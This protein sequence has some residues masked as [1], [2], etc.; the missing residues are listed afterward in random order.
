MREEFADRHS[1]RLSQLTKGHSFNTF[2]TTTTH[3][4]SGH[5]EN[6]PY[7]TM[8]ALPPKRIRRATGLG[9]SLDR[10]ASAAG[11]TWV[12]RVLSHDT[13]PSSDEDPPDR[14]AWGFIWCALTED[15]LT[16]LALPE[17]ARG[18]PAT[19]SQI[20]AVTKIHTV[21]TAF[22]LLAEAVL[23]DVHAVLA[24][25]GIEWRILKG[26]AT[27][28]LW[29]EAPDQRHT[30]DVD[31]LVHERDFWRAIEVLGAVWPRAIVFRSVSSQQAAN[32][33]TFVHETGIEIDLHRWVTGFLPAFR[34]PESAWWEHPQPLRLWWG[35]ASAMSADLMAFHVLLHL[36]SGTVRLTTV[37]D[38]LRAFARDDI[39]WNRVRGLADSRGLRTSLWWGVERANVW[40]QSQ[41]IGDLANDLH[42]GRPWTVAGQPFLGSPRARQ[43]LLHATS[44]RRTRRLVQSLRPSAE[45]L[46]WRASRQAAA[47]MAAEARQSPLQ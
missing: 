15:R 40:A 11:I 18:L 35:E 16:G 9:P 31:L 44:P 10:D 19:A 32:Q 36:T 1:V 30:A 12:R 25:N 22:D 46:A 27:A 38:L 8:D 13:A 42:P 26:L 6:V 3:S 23:R 39:D 43:L 4:L 17:I 37:A 2:R 47:T 5:T 28:H 21:H 41:R 45:F 20:A 29:Y 24:A 7:P 33:A 34:L 14:T